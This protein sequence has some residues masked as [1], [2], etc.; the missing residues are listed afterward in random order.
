MT[1]VLAALALL[2][3]PLLSW[4]VACGGGL[5]LP[6]NDPEPCPGVNTNLQVIATSSAGAALQ[7]TSTYAGGVDGTEAVYA[8][9][10]AY[11]PG[12]GLGLP[13]T[14]L[15][16]QKFLAGAS[17]TCAATQTAG[18][19]TRLISVTGCPSST[20]LN[21]CVL[22][23]RGNG[24]FTA[25]AC[26]QFTTDATQAA[27]ASGHFISD[28]EGSDFA[29][30]A[31]P[32][33]AWKTLA[34]QEALTTGNVWLKAGDV[35]Q[36]QS[37]NIFRSGTAGNPSYTGAYQMNGGTPE[38]CTIHDCLA[39]IPEVDGT[40]DATCA[41]AANCQIGGI[42]NPL[43]SSN[44]NITAGFNA[45]AQPGSVWRGL[46]DI[47]DKEYWVVQDLR[48]SN[49]AGR[50]FFFDESYTTPSKG[51]FRRVE[52]S[53]SLASAAQGNRLATAS[54]ARFQYITADRVV[55]QRVHGVTTNW[56]TCFNANSN[57]STRNVGVLGEHLTLTNCGGEGFGA[58]R[59]SNVHYRELVAANVRQNGCY[60]DATQNSVCERFVFVGSGFEGELGVGYGAE[61]AL[62]GVECYGP[63]TQHA[64]GN[65]FRNLIGFNL[66]GYALSA[67][68]E[69][70]NGCP[71]PYKSQG[72]DPAQEGFKAGLAVYN[73][74]IFMRSTA[75][76]VLQCFN[77]NVNNNLT[78]F[79][80]E[81]VAFIGGNG[82]GLPVSPQV[83]LAN[84]YF[85]SAPAAA[86]QG[87]N[88]QYGGALLTNND[89]WTAAS[90]LTSE[91]A[92]PPAGSSLINNGKALQTALLS[93]GDYANWSN[94]TE[95]CLLA[96][97]DWEKENHADFDCTVINA[98]TAPIGALHPAAP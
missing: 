2:T 29:D 68:V 55:L 88:D 39:G 67:F 11:M 72:W 97:A 8:T 56:P 90:G 53:H 66:G 41:A 24:L 33:T 83:Q 10:S 16:D 40:Y 70:N 61:L 86:C 35:W 74:T 22:S 93:I 9:T 23:K 34:M 18:N 57:D 80:V 44:P 98:L 82:C 3:A 64:E 45:N 62:A 1:R 49:S 76:N 47:R 50:A 69:R 7:W 13:A 5:T 38:V 27:T 77:C 87:T 43:Q 58:L 95:G 12:L 26:A 73:A 32:G 46:V 65:V 85:D 30:G 84:N 75:L 78:E 14:Y 31:G 59:V 17:A 96:Q 20:T 42:T 71:E 36:D 79:T 54:N 48:I 89:T 63:E 51:V 94:M 21:V 37:L 25:P 28:S 92:R 91:N 81:N 19:G 52:I 4:G 60:F 15:D 6:G